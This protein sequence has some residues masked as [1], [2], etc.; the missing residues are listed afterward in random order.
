MKPVANSHTHDPY[1]TIIDAEGTS[2]I[3][4]SLTSDSVPCRRTAPQDKACSL[5]A[6][7][8]AIGIGFVKRSNYRAFLVHAGQVREQ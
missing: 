2:L 1:E 5:L 6:Q 7:P 3:G 8:I 4:K